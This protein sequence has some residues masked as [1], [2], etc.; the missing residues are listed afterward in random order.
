V[1]HEL[2]GM[3]VAGCVAPDE[4]PPTSEE[5]KKMAHELG[6]PT[7]LIDSHLED[8]YYLSDGQRARVLAF[9][10]QIANIIA[11]IVNERQVLVDRLAAIANLTA[12]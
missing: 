6:V 10:Q 11:H 4:W 3:V 9:I 12:I 8:V 7:E 5:I 2:K 1:G